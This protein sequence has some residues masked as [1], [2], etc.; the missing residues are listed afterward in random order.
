M[1]TCYSRILSNVI[2]VGETFSSEGICYWFSVGLE[3]VLGTQKE[4]IQVH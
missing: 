1:L 4:D 2:A 3:I